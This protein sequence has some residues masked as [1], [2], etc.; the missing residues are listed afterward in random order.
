MGLFDLFKKKPAVA[1]IVA[2]CTAGKIVP[3]EDIPDEVLRQGILG[4]CVGIE[5]VDGKVYA[6][7]DGV[8]TQLTETLHAI[9]LSGVLGAEIL[10]HCG[11]DTVA[12]KGEGF[13]N[14]VTQGQSVKKGD[15]LMTM[16]LEKVKAAGYPTTIITIITNADDY[17]AVT[18]VAGD[19]VAVGDD[20]IKITK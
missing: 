19:S 11:V 8:I 9:G 20:L 3:M 7:C 10:I 4:P 5:P 16:D 1:P 17:S 18:T 12:M 2:A 15:L 14:D 13:T 6:P